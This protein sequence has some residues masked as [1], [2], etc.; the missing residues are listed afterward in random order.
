MADYGHIE[1]GHRVDICFVFL[2]GVSP[3]LRLGQRI[4]FKPSI[5]SCLKTSF[6]LGI[7]FD[8]FFLKLRLQSR[9]EKVT[10]CI[11]ICEA[12]YIMFREAIRNA[13]M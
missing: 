1:N 11:Y 7:L 12:T 5:R 8:N 13:K 6:R 10:D 3:V 9:D 2:V 4:D